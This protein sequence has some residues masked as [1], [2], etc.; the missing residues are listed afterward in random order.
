LCQKVCGNGRAG[1]WENENRGRGANLRGNRGESISGSSRKKPKGGF[2][3][4]KTKWNPVWAIKNER[5]GEIGGVRKKTNRENE[6]RRDC[7][8]T[9]AVRHRGK[10]IEG[11]L[12][13][14]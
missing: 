11:S 8:G 13:S 6:G 2:K 1:N 3:G 10:V 12:Q 14:G 4:S 7:K 9:E 5:R